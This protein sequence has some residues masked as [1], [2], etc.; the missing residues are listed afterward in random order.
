[1]VPVEVPEDVP[2]VAVGEAVAADTWVVN[3]PEA[4][5]KRPVRPV[6][7]VDVPEVMV[8]V[9]EKL[10]LNVLELEANV[11]GRTP[12]TAMTAKIVGTIIIVFILVSTP[13]PRFVSLS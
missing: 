8:K 13:P 11:T 5:T 2:V 4:C 6:M 1:M 10:P 12:S 7:V 9:P 3:E